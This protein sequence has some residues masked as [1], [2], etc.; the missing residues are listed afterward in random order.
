MEWWIRLKRRMRLFQ[1]YYDIY[2]S[3]VLMQSMKLFVLDNT[4]LWRSHFSQ[5]PSNAKYCIIAQIE[6]DNVILLTR[7]SKCSYLNFI[8]RAPF[9]FYRR[10]MIKSL[11]KYFLKEAVS[12]L[13]LSLMW[14]LVLFVIR[15]YYYQQK[16]IFFSENMFLDLFS[17]DVIYRI[18]KLLLFFFFKLGWNSVPWCGWCGREGCN[19]QL[20][21]EISP[22]PAGTPMVWCH[23][24]LH[25]CYVYSGIY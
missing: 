6:V 23:L 11:L 10:L 18:L 17:P 20:P 22:H 5:S 2:L 15:L 12:S 24:Y 25:V 21:E 19:F 14:D 9:I 16:Y 13:Q 3:F 8:K 7:E 4:L 1:R